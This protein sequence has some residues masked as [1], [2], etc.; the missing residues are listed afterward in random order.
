MGV[1]LKQEFVTASNSP[2]TLNG[3]L[4]MSLRS[5]FALSLFSTF[6][7]AQTAA[8]VATPSAAAPPPPISPV[9]VQ[10]RYW[11]EQF[12]QWPSADFPYSMIEFDADPNHGKPLYSLVLTDHAGKRLYYVNDEQLLA[13]ARAFNDTVALAKIAFERPEAAAKDATYTMRAA[14]PDGTPVQWRFVQGSDIMEAGGGITPLPTIPVPV[15]AYREEGA[16]AG[17]GTAIAIGKQ[18]SS[19][20]VWTEISH[21]PYFVAY[22]GA[23]STNA[24]TIVFS[25]GKEI[26]KI[27]SAPTSVTNG[28]TW[29]LSDGNG[30][31][32]TLTILRME[33]THA[34][35]RDTDSAYARSRRTVTATFTDKGWQIESIHFVPA[36]EEKHAVTVQF[37]EKEAVLNI[38]KKSKIA[39]ADVEMSPSG[40]NVTFK[41]PDWVKGKGTQSRVLVTKDDITIAT[42]PLK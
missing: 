21:P 5:L 30:R 37:S 17:D 11:P 15:F 34:T 1:A 35:I 14:L 39:V 28:A 16:V 26:W 2:S 42:R 19:A 10:Y 36:D 9:S 38:G 13:E 27:D 32:R 41:S 23:Y 7:F 12:V 20:E 3:V 33:G 29:K 40:A 18:V 4:A 31:T 25:A 6:A 22:R 24:H 8:P